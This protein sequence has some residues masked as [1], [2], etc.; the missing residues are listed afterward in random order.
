MQMIYRILFILVTSFLTACG[1]SGVPQLTSGP[2]DQDAKPAPVQSVPSG[3]SVARKGNLEVES[4]DCRWT[5]PV[6][7]TESVFTNL[8]LRNKSNKNVTSVQ[9]VVTFANTAGQSVVQNFK[10]TKNLIPDQVNVNGPN[11]YPVNQT[12]QAGWLLKSCTVKVDQ[13]DYSN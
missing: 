8:I 4:Y 1:S 7:G 13:V 5:G 12:W 6:A 10:I 3:P 11:V 9:G 2:A